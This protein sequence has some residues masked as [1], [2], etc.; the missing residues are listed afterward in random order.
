MK[1]YVK[2]NKRQVG[3]IKY[4]IS[5]QSKKNKERKRKNKLQEEP[6]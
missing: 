3:A 2:I 1:V 4:L 6:Q 5:N